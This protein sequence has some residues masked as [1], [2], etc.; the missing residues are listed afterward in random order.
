MIRQS[1]Y[2]LFDNEK[3]IDYGVE[4]V[5]TESGL[6]EESFL[7][8]RSVNETYVKGRSEPYTEGVKREAKQ[9]PLNFYVGENYDEKKIRAIKRWLDVDDYK[10]LAF[11]ENLDIV[12]YAM[13]VDTSDLVH[14]A[15]RHGYVRLTMKCNSP[16]AYSQNTST[17]SF[18]ISSGMKIIELH[19]KG[20]VVIYPT[21]EI[22][23]IGDGDV[24]IENLSDYTEPFIFSNLKDREIVKVNGDKEI[25]ESSLYGNERYDDFNDNYIRLDYGKNRLKVT[26][27]C[28]L[29]LTF[30]FKYR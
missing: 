28:K 26:G 11:S 20:D 1:Q 4:N 29:R 15:A 16:Y 24:K 6:V 18:D 21:V 19:N 25:I 27:K 17:H 3:S 30:R 13:P 23:K 9:F 2:F 12:Y 10:P 14:N 5:N 8:S 7:G 22:L